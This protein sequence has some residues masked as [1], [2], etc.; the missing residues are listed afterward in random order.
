MSSPKQSLSGLMFAVL[1]IGIGFAPAVRVSAGQDVRPEPP[2]LIRKSSAV[3]LASVTK[4]IEPAYPPLAKAARINGAVVVEVTADEEGNVISGRAIS[5]HPLLKDAAVAAATGWK[6][7]PTM[8]S[9]V[10]V[11]VI[12]LITFNFRF[13]YSKDIEAVK[14]QLAAE[15]NSAQLHQKLGELLNADGQPEKAIEELNQALSLGGDSSQILFAIG[16]AYLLS[17]RFGEATDAYKRAL[18][19]NSLPGFA[20]MINMRLGDAYLSQELNELALEV[21]KQVAVANPESPSAHFKL[22]L[23]Y[24][25]IGDKQSAMNEYNILKDLSPQL[26]DMLHRELG[27]KNN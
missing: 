25:K 26:A 2:K 19:T 20:E 23:T 16:E 1:A 13:D 11:K 9:G 18:S 6:F 27:K 17:K 15:P 7:S 14:E 12:G 24:L 22:G 8:L 4:R 5:G 10:P 3:F 21:F